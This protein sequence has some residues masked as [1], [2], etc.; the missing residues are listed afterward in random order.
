MKKYSHAFSI[1]FSVDSDR[2]GND[3]TAEEL[4]AGI[5]RRLYMLKQQELDSPECQQ[6]IIEACGLPYDTGENEEEDK[7]DARFTRTIETR[8][9]NND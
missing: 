6:E 7:R 5:L 1:S 3:I 2:D 4:W 8:R 9:K